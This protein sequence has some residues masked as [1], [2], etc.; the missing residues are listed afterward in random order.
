MSDVSQGPGW[1]Q[2]TDGKWYPPRWEYRIEQINLAFKHGRAQSESTLR[3]LGL[4]GWE[5]VG[6]T[7][8]PAK[9]T[10]VLFKR[11]VP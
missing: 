1:W 4:E 11:M 8:E 3:T 6:L 2:A 10:A 5:A 9:G 7:G